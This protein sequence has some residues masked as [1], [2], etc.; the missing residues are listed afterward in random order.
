MLKRVLHHLLKKKKNQK[1]HNIEIY[2]NIRC[3]PR[4]DFS[5]DIIKFFLNKSYLIIINF[6][7]NNNNNNNIVLNTCKQILRHSHPNTTTRHI[8][9]YIITILLLFMIIFFA[10][11][12]VQKPFK[13]IRSTF[14]TMLGFIGPC[15]CIRLLSCT[16]TMSI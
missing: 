4:P 5:R 8:S 1:Q 6:I 3:R 7:T 9:K 2:N 12:T 14:S 13:R 15:S 10:G 11:I 16:S